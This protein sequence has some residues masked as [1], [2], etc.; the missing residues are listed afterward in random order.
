MLLLWRIFVSISQFG[1]TKQSVSTQKGNDLLMWSLG[2]KFPTIFNI[3]G[4]ALG[5]SHFPKQFSSSWKFS[6]NT[7]L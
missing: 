5:M 1:K 2:Q 3:C 4:D 6:F 7:E